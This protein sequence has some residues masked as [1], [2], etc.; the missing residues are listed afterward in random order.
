MLATGE[1]HKI[2]SAINSI[3]FKNSHCLY[4]IEKYNLQISGNC[5]IYIARMKYYSHL[6]LNWE[7]TIMKLH[8]DTQLPLKVGSQP[9]PLHEPRCGGNPE[10]GM[11]RASAKTDSTVICI[12]PALPNSVAMF[13][14]AFCSFLY[15]YAPK[16]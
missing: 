10:R 16:E 3:S 7:C 11:W 5:K 12:C 2:T 6:K 9:S 15:W 14:A 13:A 4:S 1:S 8:I